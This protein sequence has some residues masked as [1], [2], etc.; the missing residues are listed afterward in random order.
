MRSIIKA[1]IML[2]LAAGSILMLGGALAE[3]DATLAPAAAETAVTPEV[4]ADPEDIPPTI[5]PSP[6]PLPRLP[7]LSWRAGNNA[8]DSTVEVIPSTVGGE[9]Y[10]FLP[11]CADLTLFALTFEQPQLTLSH[12]GGA[13]LTVT[14]G[15]AFDLTA[16]C[17]PDEE[18]VYRLTV[19][20]PAQSEPFTL[21]IMR[22]ANQ[23]ALWVVSDDPA[24]A[25]RAYVDSAP[26]RVRYTARGSLVMLDE[27]GEPVYQGGLREIRGRGNTT[28]DWGVK[29]PYQI[30]LEN[31][32]DLL[33]NGSNNRARTWLLL[34]ESF[35]ATLLHNTLCLSLGQAL[36]LSATPEFRP[37]DLYYDGEYRGYY[38]LCEKVQVASGRLDIMNYS[39]YMEELYPDIEDRE[40]YPLKEAENAYGNTYQ[41]VEGVS[42]AT[43][44][45]GAYLIELDAYN[46]TG[47]ANWFTVS[48]SEPF[49]VKSPEYA[50]KADME[51]LS[52]RMQELVDAVNNGGINPTTGRPLSDYLDYDSMARVLLVNALAKTCDFGYTSTYFY[53]PEGSQRFFAGPLWD[54]DIA[55]GIRDNRPMEVG[56]DNYIPFSGWLRT[57]LTVPDFQQTM[58]R[59]FMEEFE[60]L[61]SQVLLNA[62]GT[63]TDTLRP[64][65]D[66]LSRIEASRRM[67][68]KLWQYGGGY[69]NINYDTL[70]DTYEANLAFFRAYLTNRMAWLKGDMAL[71][72][73]TMV[74]RVGLSL[75]YIN[76]KVNE[77]ATITAFNVF[78]QYAITDVSWQQEP[79]DEM[80]WRHIYTADI[81]LTPNAGITFDETVTA[82]VN[83]CPAQVLAQDDTG[84][85][86]RF[87]FSAPFYEEALYDDVDYGLLFQYDYYIHQYPELLDEYGDDRE[88][89]LAN[90]VSY[91]LP[92]EV[93]AIET[94]DYALYYEAYTRLLDNYF[95]GDAMMSTLFYLDNDQ[96]GPLM[97]LGEVI[98]PEGSDEFPKTEVQNP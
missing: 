63:P 48:G 88:A 52:C 67:N 65:D 93:S 54:F 86:V 34:A 3:G 84:L 60:P 83:G 16:L 71:W 79:D 44:G 23:A 68:Y 9:T 80:P 62:E 82:T 42:G 18:G 87:R 81:R 43:D 7:S 36:G 89:I 58:L 39:D 32:T 38:L 77:S 91:D 22:S 5:A 92:M 26:S 75:S 10:L 57:I 2:W 70:Y 6:T 20:Q 15:E 37:V 74:D 12:P 17:T 11:S 35:D 28:W 72:S 76:A 56:T 61:V 8:S 94:F 1:V 13:S 14:S 51:Y 59:I 73:G 85:T 33:Q 19:S 98:Y 30:K 25:G 96:E 40:A 64:L 55:F 24:R 50:P 46:F 47:E 31:K 41:Y 97:G 66:Y 90:Y 78:P 95:M 69:N 4:A 53:M 27:Q 29:K 45:Q 21:C 49:A